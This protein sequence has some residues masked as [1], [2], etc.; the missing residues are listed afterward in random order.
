MSSNLIRLEG[1]GIR[2]F[3]SIDAIHTW[4]ISEMTTVEGMTSAPLLWTYEGSLRVRVLYVIRQ[5]NM[6]CMTK[7][8]RRTG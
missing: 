8:A 2:V 6:A 5:A 1:C 3:G 4:M 7:A